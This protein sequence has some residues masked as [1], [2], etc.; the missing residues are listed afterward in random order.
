MR[1]LAPRV[2]VVVVVDV[3]SF[4]TTVD[5]ALSSGVIVFPY[6]WH[7]GSELE[8]ASQVGATVASRRGEPGLTLSPAAVA[9]A[10][11]GTRLVLPSPNGATLTHGAM[12]MGAQ[13]VLVG[14]LRNA[15]AIAAAVRPEETVA[16]IAAGERWAGAAG[17]LRPAI[18]DQLGAGAIIDALDRESCSPEALVAQAT[19]VDL[20]VS[21]IV[22]QCGSGQELSDAGFAKDVELAVQVDC[23]EMV[24]ELQGMQ[25]VHASATGHRQP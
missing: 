6:R 8:F 15:S 14:C 16:V 19:Y 11:P 13:R 4:S 2:D 10:Q 5:V 12:E 3:L 9:A 18:E 24:P 17:P 7:D 21:S 20:D 1:L 22:T 23:S 25:L